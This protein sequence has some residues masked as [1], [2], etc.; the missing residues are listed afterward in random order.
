LQTVREEERTKIARKL[1]DDISQNLA[2]LKIEMYMLGKEFPKDKK[3]VHAGIES[4]MGITDRMTDTVAKI[5]TEL[6]PPLLDEL[7]LLGAIKWYQGKWEEYTEIK[8]EFHIEPERVDMSDDHNLAVFRI[9]QESLTNVR[10]HSEATRAKVNLREKDGK[11][12]LIVKDNGIGITDE[13]VREPKAFG[14]KGME[15]RVRH[16]GGE[17]KIKGV[18]GKGTTVTV[19]IPLQA[20]NQDPSK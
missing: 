1:H 7:G 2:I 11:L 19:R 6:R 10:L 18:A 5:F 12:E 3:P 16:L 14:I 8:C 4:M 17:L 15:E 13:Q 9:L 20:D